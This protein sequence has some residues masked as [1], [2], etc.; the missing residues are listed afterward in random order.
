VNDCHEQGPTTG[1]TSAGPHH[2]AATRIRVTAVLIALYAPLD[3]LA[4]VSLLVSMIIGLVAL[5]AMTAYQVWATPYRP[6][7]GPFAR[8]SRHN[9][10]A[11][12]AAVLGHPFPDVAHQHQQL[13][14]ARIDRT[15]S[16]YFTVTVFATVGFGDI[17]PASQMARLVVTAQ[18]IL[19]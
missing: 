2:R 15:D 10:P 6:A 18:M 12:P 16:L 17:F 4:G 13:Q 1:P 9:R 8:G 7:W 5:A 3:H 11:V 19:T 14:R